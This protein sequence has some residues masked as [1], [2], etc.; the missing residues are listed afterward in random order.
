M[1]FLVPPCQFSTGETERSRDQPTV[2][3]S[4]AESDCRVRGLYQ[5]IRALMTFVGTR[6]SGKSSWIRGRI[7]RAP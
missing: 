4:C 7:V 6:N 1:A 2:K 3:S 5:G